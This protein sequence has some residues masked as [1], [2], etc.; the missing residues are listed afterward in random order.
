MYA[1]WKWKIN[2]N[3]MY[4]CVFKH[5][6]YTT[7]TSIHTIFPKQQGEPDQAEKWPVKRESML[8]MTMA[9]IY[10]FTSVYYRWKNIK[11]MCIILHWAFSLSIKAMAVWSEHIFLCAM[12]TTFWYCSMTTTLTFSKLYYCLCILI[13]RDNGEWKEKRKK[14]WWW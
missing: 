5:T 14:R 3:A 11:I 6:F 13:S 12:P 9:Y 10:I 7:T 8:E 4:V 1:K 2:I